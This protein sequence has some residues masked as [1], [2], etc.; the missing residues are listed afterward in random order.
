[1]PQPLKSPITSYRGALAN[2]QVS[3]VQIWRLEDW[4]EVASIEGPFEKGFV[5][6]TFSLRLGW[7]PDGQNL[8]AVNSYD[9]PCH[10]VAL[11]KRQSWDFPQTMVGHQGILPRLLVHFSCIV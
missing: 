4:E 2:I 6:M 1:M 9:P 3:G 10:L 8:A 7:S 5:S 11:L